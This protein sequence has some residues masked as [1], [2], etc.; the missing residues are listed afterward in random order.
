MACC[1]EQARAALPLQM[2]TKTTTVPLWSSNPSLP[3]QLATLVRTCYVYL[4]ACVPVFSIRV[5]FK[6]VTLKKLR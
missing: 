2:W 5:L 3:Q 4:Y 1:L 6:T